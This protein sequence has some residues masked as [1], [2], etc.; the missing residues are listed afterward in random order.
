[1]NVRRPL[2]TLVALLALAAA[3]AAGASGSVAVDEPPIQPAPPPG[4]Y[5]RVAPQPSWPSFSTGPVPD[6]RPYQDY[7]AELGVTP[8][9]TGEGI[10]IANIEYEW[11]AGHSDLVGRGLP[12][13]A[14]TGLP[15]Y[16][17]ARDHGTAVLALLGATDDSTGISGLA[18]AAELSPRSP[19]Y[20]LTSGATATSYQPARAINAAADGLR[21]GD[22]LLIELQALVTLP[23]Q[24][25][26]LGPIEY[27]DTPRD[28]VRTAIE[29]AVSR[30]IV[31]VE[32]AGNGDL[33]LASLGKSWLM[34][35][36]D[37][38]A[39]G[40][41]MVG[42]GGSGVGVPSVGDRERVPGSNYGAR[43]DVQGFGAAVVTAGYGDL[44]GS[45][46][47]ADRAYTACFDGTSSASASVAAAAALI[48]SAAVAR[49][50]KPLSPA[51]VRALL[52][53]TGRPQLPLPEDKEQ[54]TDNIGPR[55]DVGAAVD[56]LSGSPRPPPPTDGGI[57]TPPADDPLAKP[58]TTSS[59]SVAPAPIANAAVLA[60]R[61]L[62]LRLD[63]RARRL[64]IVVRGAAPSAIVHV[65]PRRISLHRG[66]L[67]LGNVTPGRF[68]LSVR[69][70]DALA[71]REVAFRVTVPVRGA[72]KL[73]RL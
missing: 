16:F 51:K 28:P 10:R 54:R 52:V 15:S 21:A 44:S 29:K 32:P 14:A 22:V 55:P 73:T 57:T 45:A 58:T 72:P 60:A 4:S 27:H 65:G 18:P 71:Y 53:E 36:G 1:M 35:A 64:V 66:R 39:T 62:S 40:A 26:V 7:R 61:G 19:F 8:G 24:R 50:G 67:V 5:C 25:T 17:R 11:S 63:R 42:A 23:D 46:A 56:A 9:L 49:T 20:P 30:G 31:V 43:V 70:A 12:S 41:L 13:S 33:D 38:L 59:V 6:L 47:G 37:P 68:V 69:S 2:A 48:Q 3:A 34:G